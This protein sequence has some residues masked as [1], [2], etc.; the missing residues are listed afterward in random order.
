[1]LSFFPSISVFM[2]VSFSADGYERRDQ[3]IGSQR[4]LD[5]ERRVQVAIT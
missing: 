2:Y 5:E 4:A 3:T 1:M